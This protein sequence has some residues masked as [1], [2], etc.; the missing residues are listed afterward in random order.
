[1]EKTGNMAM[2]PWTTNPEGEERRVGVELEMNGLTLDGLTELVARQLGMAIEDKGRYERA[3]TGDPA[4]DWGVELDFD[5][6]KRMGREERDT[7]SFA[8]GAFR[9]RGP[10]MAGR[11]PGAPG[12]GEPAAAPEPAPRG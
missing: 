11:T 12:A 6:L 5:L 9:R 3:L 10:E 4:G 8:A 1:M 2:P 7:G